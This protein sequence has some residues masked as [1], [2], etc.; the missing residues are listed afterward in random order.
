MDEQT[1]ERI[2]GDNVRA[3]TMRN[4]NK[5]VREEDAACFDESVAWKIDYGRALTDLVLDSA[6]SIE[7]D[8]PVSTRNIIDRRLESRRSQCNGDCVIAI[9]G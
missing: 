7:H 6:E 8:G 5:N 3:T 2:Q 9:M 1:V 4:K